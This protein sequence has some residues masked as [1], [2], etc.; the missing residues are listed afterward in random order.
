MVFGQ[1]CNPRRLLH[2]PHTPSDLPVAPLLHRPPPSLPLAN[3]PSSVRREAV[4][5][6]P[7]YSEALHGGCQAGA[8]LSRAEDHIQKFF[9][10]PLT[11]VGSA[12]GSGRL[13]GEVDGCFVVGGLKQ[14]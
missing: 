1:I 8:A 7:Q 2:P 14:K 5:D 12:L 9:H 10:A 6:G 11:T 13:G 3:G 4:G